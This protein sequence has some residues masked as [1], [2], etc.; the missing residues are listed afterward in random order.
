M[1]KYCDGTESIFD[2]RKPVMGVDGDVGIDVYLQDGKMIVDCLTQCNRRDYTLSNVVG[3]E[4]ASID[5]DF[6]PK[7]GTPLGEVKPLT[8]EQLVERVGKPIWCEWLQEEDRAIEHGKWFI[9]VSEKDG[10]SVKCPLD[11]GSHVC[12]LN[13][14]G[15]GWLAFDREPKGEAK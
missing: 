3:W 8:V 4:D 11:F 15:I 12:K 6:C 5:V 9:V 13:N 2:S 1:C 14:Y 7:C 10:F